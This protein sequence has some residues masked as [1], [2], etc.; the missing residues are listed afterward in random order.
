MRNMKWKDVYIDELFDEL[1]LRALPD[2]ENPDC[3][4]GPVVGA[5][6]EKQREVVEWM[7]WEIWRLRVE[8][9]DARR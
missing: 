1:T 8:L 9:R 2:P 7:V 6:S 5:F 3:E 4:I